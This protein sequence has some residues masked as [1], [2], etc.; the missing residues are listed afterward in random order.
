MTM[1]MTTI[2]NIRAIYNS[3]LSPVQYVHEQEF[4]SLGFTYISPHYANGYYTK[5]YHCSD[6]HLILKTINLVQ[7]KPERKKQFLKESCKILEYVGRKVIVTNVIQVFGIF[8]INDTVYV[9]MRNYPEKS[10]HCK[11]RMMNRFTETLVH[12]WIRQLASVC[13]YLFQKNIVHRLELLLLLLLLLYIFSYTFSFI[14]VY[15]L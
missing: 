3:T 6:P 12:R 1:S 14:F 5:F 8:Q 15:F 13:A 4:I 10:I 9:F 11:M 2:D 7:L